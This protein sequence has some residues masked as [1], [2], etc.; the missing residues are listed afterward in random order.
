MLLQRLVNKFL[1]GVG[2][3]D[4][5]GSEESADQKPFSAN[6]PDSVKVGRVHMIKINII[7]SVEN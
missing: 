4:L 5:T 7:K 3:G 2:K 1:T 6:V